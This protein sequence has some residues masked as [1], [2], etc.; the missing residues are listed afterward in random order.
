MK[1]LQPCIRVLYKN[2]DY[3][4][5]QLGPVGVRNQLENTDTLTHMMSE[6]FQQ[7]IIRKAAEAIKNKNTAGNEQLS[8]QQ[9]F[10]KPQLPDSYKFD[11]DNQAQPPSSR[12]TT[13]DESQQVSSAKSFNIQFDEYAEEERI[14]END[15][16][17]D[18]PTDEQLA[19][20]QAASSYAPKNEKLPDQFD[21]YAPVPSDLKIL[22]YSRLLPNPDFFFHNKL[23]KSGSS[24]MNQL[25]NQL[26][27]H[28]TKSFE[29]LFIK[30]N[31]MTFLI[32]LSKYSV[33]L[34]LPKNVAK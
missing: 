15:D 2:N 4:Y 29:N 25:L 7:T 34:Q 3:M 21:Y 22:D 5:S 6:D 12:Q 9:E 10:H 14:Q 16:I 17:T 19:R 32:I 26:R 33:Y 8:Q 23:P 13:I 18:D 24:T 11:D 1:H 27:K 31:D 30:E 28:N 20:L